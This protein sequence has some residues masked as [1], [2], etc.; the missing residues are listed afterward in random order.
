MTLH[1]WDADNRENGKAELAEPERESG[2]FKD[3]RCLQSPHDPLY[4]CLYD[5]L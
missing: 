3:G 1:E 4:P 2:K 5:H